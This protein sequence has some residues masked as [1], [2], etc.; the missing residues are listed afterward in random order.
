MKAHT[1][2]DYKPYYPL[3][4][5]NRYYSPYIC[6]IIPKEDSCYFAFIDNGKKADSKYKVFLKERYYREYCS[7]DIDGF[8][9]TF[10]NL[11]NNTDYEFYIQR[12]E[13]VKS[14]IRLFRT[15]TVI[16][17][18][19]NYLHKDDP[20]YSFSGRYLCS[21][22]LVKLPS[23]KLISSM[24]VFEGNNC[25]NLTVLFESNDNGKTWSYLNELFPCFWGQLFYEND[26]LYMLS[27]STE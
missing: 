17:T 25:Q 12:D 19:V 18:I 9:F 7:F 1:N 3:D 20:Y 2:W 24:D 15:G 27:A 22:S 26:R 16:G 11:K 13:D 14:E 4:R 23:G 8:S 5:I 10:S 21:P 6:Q